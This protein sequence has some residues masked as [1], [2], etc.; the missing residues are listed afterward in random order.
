VVL[1]QVDRAIL[2]QAL[3]R[4]DGQLGEAAKFLGIDRNTFARK[5]RKL[6]V[7][8]ERAAEPAPAASPRSAAA[9]GA[10]R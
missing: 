8:T 5:A 6:K 4:A 7:K 2:R 9:N 10:R 1:E 3:E